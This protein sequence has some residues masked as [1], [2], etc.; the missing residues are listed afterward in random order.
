MIGSRNDRRSIEIDEAYESLG[1][2]MCD[3]ILGFHAFTGRDQISRFT[4]K[5]KLTCWKVFKSASENILKAFS[6]LGTD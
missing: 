5:S 2:E 1:P 3:A 6:L 4:G